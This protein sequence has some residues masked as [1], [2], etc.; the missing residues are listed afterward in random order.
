M[1]TPEAKAHNDQGFATDLLE[2][3]LDE[4]YRFRTGA[5]PRTEEDAGSSKA[6]GKDKQKKKKEAQNADEAS[7]HSQKNSSAT[8]SKSSKRKSTEDD[9]CFDEDTP[10]DRARDKRRKPAPAAEDLDNSDNDDI[11][12]EDEDT[13]NAAPFFNFDDEG[14]GPP[15]QYGPRGDDD[16]AFTSGSDEDSDAKGKTRNKKQRKNKKPEGGRRRDKAHMDTDKKNNFDKTIRYRGKNLF[17]IHK[18]RGDRLKKDKDEEKRIEDFF[19]NIK[20]NDNTMHKKSVF[21]GTDMDNIYVK[22]IKCPIC[23]SINSSR[24]GNLTAYDIM[25]DYDIMN[26]RKTNARDL[27]Q[28]MANAFNKWQER[29]YRRGGNYIFVTFDM[30]KEHI[31]KCDTSSPYRTLVEQTVITKEIITK[32]IPFAFGVADDGSKVCNESKSKLLLQYMKHGIHLDDKM[33]D[34]ELKLEQSMNRYGKDALVGYNMKRGIDNKNSSDI[35]NRKG[36]QVQGYFK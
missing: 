28:Q 33:M 18:F 1:T 25:K 4:N 23:R 2:A 12:I 17:E 29:I 36:A 9:S 22:R 27:Y 35:V 6:K 11:D 30:M 26:I 8:G 3:L 31:E 20:P 14:G 32:L 13:D 5:P 21:D 15:P 34:R 10:R 7:T 24:I 16:D 19:K